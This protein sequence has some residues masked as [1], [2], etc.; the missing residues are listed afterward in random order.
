[1]PK[2][3]EQKLQRF[4]EFA[5][6][7]R[8]QK[9]QRFIEF[10]QTEEEQKLTK[11]LASSLQSYVSIKVRFARWYSFMPKTAMEKHWNGKAWHS[12]SPFWY[13]EAI[14]YIFWSFG[15]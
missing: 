2:L 15:I 13:L 4:I 14:W 6:A 9:L 1:L 8:E 7:E 11:G 5:Q 12:L 10:A 3:K